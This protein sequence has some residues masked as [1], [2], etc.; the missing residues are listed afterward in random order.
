MNDRRSFVLAGMAALTGIA[1]LEWIR[2]RS[3][4]GGAPWPLRRAL[5]INE[6]LSSRVFGSRRPARM[7]PSHASGMPRENG[8][9]GL[10]E[11]FEPQSWRLLVSSA[12]HDQTTQLSLRELQALPRVE[13]VTELCCIEGWSR[14]VRWSGFRFSSLV[15]K[16][17]FE[18]R[19]VSLET[20]DQTY[21]VGLDIASAVHP[22]TLLC[23]AMEGSPLSSPHGAPLRLVVPVKYGI[24]SIKRIGAIRFTNTRPRDYWADRG[25]DWYA[26]L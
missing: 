23:D 25:Y 9:E 12:T 13:M 22:Q 10:D 15:E 4:V 11:P 1:G 21:Y 5:E 7:F 18:S 3:P 19:Y 14:I 26:G 20:P 2:T 17:G 8:A 6:A 24:K 16:V